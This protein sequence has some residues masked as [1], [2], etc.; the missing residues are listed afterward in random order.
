MIITSTELQNNFGKYL[1]LAVKED[2]F[3]SR[4]GTVIA[5]LSPIS[6]V[7]GHPGLMR[8]TVYE[9]QEDYSYIGY[10]KTAS[11]EEFMKLRNN[12]DERIE[13]IDG[14]IYFLASPKR[15][16]QAA[17]VELFGIFYNTFKG[18]KCKPM[19]APFD[20]EMKRT[21]EN[22]SMVQPDLM[23]IC[24]LEEKLGDDDYYKGVPDLI[25]EI[26]SKSTQMVDIVKKLDLYLACGVRE[27]W[28][29]NP[30]NQE[31]TVYQFKESTIQSS[32]TFKTN[33]TIQSFI[34]DDLA[35]ELNDIFER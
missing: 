7:E 2:I 15:A 23:I 27:Y 1:L 35:V 25:V 17:L 22:I 3:I 8:E 24:D 30:W 14:Q 18:K 21:P 12:T 34:F 6:E 20:I 10:G 32:K 29:V 16:H 13:Y 31:V 28:I 33:E 11:F 26:L 19:V 9:K 4:N 5:K